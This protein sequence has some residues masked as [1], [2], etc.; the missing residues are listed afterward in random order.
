MEEI[1]DLSFRWWKIYGW[2]GLVVGVPYSIVM[3]FSSHSLSGLFFLL[4]ILTGF[5]SVF[6]LQYNRAAFLWATILSLNPLLWIIN[7]VYLKNRWNHP[8]VLEGSLKIKESVPEIKPT[9]K[10]EAKDSVP[11]P[12]TRSVVPSDDDFRLAGEEVDRGDYEKGL[13][14]RLYAETDGDLGKT[15]A[16]Y[17]GRR[18]AQ[19]ASRS[20]HYDN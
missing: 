2:L 1:K 4:A 17:V 15:R 7:G 12:I 14:E 19:I 6:I 9:E 20:A 16:R 11:Q 13:W 5:I 3:G 10:S 8:A 18:A